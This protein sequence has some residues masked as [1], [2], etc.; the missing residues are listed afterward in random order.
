LNSKIT[1]T[2]MA[3]DIRF[4]G[5][6]ASFDADRVGAKAATLSRLAARFD[7]PPGFCL[8]AAVFDRL[9]SALDGDDRARSELR[10]L[11]AS[12]QQQL[13]ARIDGR[14]IAM[15]VR[16][17]AIGEDG[18]D[19]S[20]A[21]QHE[22]ILGV[23]G[24]DAIVDAVLAC[25][26]SVSSERA[27]A[28]RRERGIDGPARIA[29]LIQELVDA[30]VAAIAFSADPVSGDRDVVVVN[31]SWGLGESLASGAVTPDTFVV[32]KRDLAVIATQVADKQV[33]TVRRDRGT[34]EVPVEDE[35]RTRPALEEEAVREVARLALA[36][37]KET[38]TPVDVECAFVGGRLVLLQ[39][40][41]ITAVAR[42]ERFPVT[43]SDPA[44]AQIT[45]R[46]DEAHYGE[47][48][49]P[50]SAEYVV[51][52]PSFGLRRRNEMLGP[53]VL[54]RFQPQNGWI[55]FGARPL[56]PPSEM[57]RAQQLATERLRELAR[58]LPLLWQNEYLPSVRAHYEW[59][60]SLPIDS[61]TAGQAAESWDEL[62]RR[63]NDVW[64]TH[65]LVV[66]GAY[67]VMEELAESYEQLTGRSGA[68][69]LELVQGRAET[70]QR[71][72]S[73]LHRLVEQIRGEA[74]LAAAIERA[75]VRSIEEIRA[76]PGGREVA[77]PI[78][79]FLAAHGDVGQALSDLRSPP[80][81][82][83]QSLFF[84]EIVR[85][86][87]SPGDDPAARLAELRAHAESTEERARSILRDRP[88]D[89]VRFDEVLAAA[90]G[91]GPLTEEHNYW[92]DGVVQ[93]H[94][95][96]AVMAFGA[97]FVRDSQLDDADQIFL[98][99]IPEL[100]EALRSRDDLRMLAHERETSVRRA[101]R[102]RP[103]PTLG[104]APSA[105]EA[106]TGSQLFDKNYRV[107][108]TDPRVLKGVPASAGVGR[109]PVRLVDGAAAFSRFRSGDVLVCRS[110]NVSWVP[111]FALAAA[112]VT[113]VGGA[114]S[115][116][117]V[118]AREFGVPAVVGTGVALSELVDGELVEV[119]G[120]AG[121]VRRVRPR[122]EGGL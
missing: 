8:A 77:V 82:D 117:A 34:E 63:V 43:W 69:A 3:T 68:E 67:A 1:L 83:D 36:L 24:V 17:S 29:V 60:R 106:A 23:R 74:P 11:V 93:A 62:W 31:A 90:Q 35:R 119:D 61:L 37:E 54:V 6:A 39:S 89:L 32:R 122:P 28:Y 70:L 87:R 15:A 109:G 42:D 40:R 7:V 2:F 79:S 49:W 53:P 64:T 58:R 12:A 115:H 105:G 99:H 25:W 103:P 94:V 84:D 107:V 38:G 13:D 76:L 10:A 104:P 47:H 113:E 116:A 19:A 88:E 75:E 5:E 55:Y 46:R 30:D 80:W 100:R 57:P 81:S 96:R 121:V 41:P 102:M 59:M 65:M 56:I 45:W 50:L 95:R 33:M 44:D 66:G 18:L 48:L 73:E 71:M 85:R 52:G 22:T 98:F 110:S 20:F 97:R 86:L 114:L 27:L 101:A 120:T 4:L 108:Q 92:I 91:A 78:E 14:P 118:V 21:G 72:Q 16:S 111:L 51:Q 9:A 26:R 112:V